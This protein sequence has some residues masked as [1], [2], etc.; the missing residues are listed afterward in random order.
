MTGKQIFIR[1]MNENHQ[2]FLDFLKHQYK[3]YKGKK[4]L[5]IDEMIQKYQLNEKEIKELELILNN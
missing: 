3:R 1:N 2:L 4:W 5:Y